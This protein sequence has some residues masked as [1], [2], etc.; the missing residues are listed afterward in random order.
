MPDGLYQPYSTQLD[1]WEKTMCVMH[2]SY[3]NG[4]AEGVGRR[5]WQQIPSPFA[6]QFHYDLVISSQSY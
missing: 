5:D 6:S 4:S 1:Q 2:P 3:Q